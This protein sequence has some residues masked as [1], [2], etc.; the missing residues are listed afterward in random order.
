MSRGARGRFRRHRSPEIGSASVMASRSRDAM[1]NIKNRDA[2]LDRTD[3][4]KPAEPDWPDAEFIVGNPPFLGGN[5]VRRE[6]GDDYVAS[7]FKIWGERLPNFSDLCCYWFEK[8]RAMIGAG[9]VKRAGL[10]STQGIRGGANRTVL[11]R[12]S[13][14]GGIYFARSDMDWVLDGATVH[15]S[16]VGFDDGSESQ[17]ELDGKVVGTINPSLLRPAW[18]MNPY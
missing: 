15:I 16:M 3:P 6:L 1:D 7:L 2:I 8:A 9:R 5:R 11:E 14:S 4:N 12:I 17:R 10:L 18:A 13:Q